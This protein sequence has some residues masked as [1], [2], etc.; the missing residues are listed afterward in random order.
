MH[1]T[2]IAST[3]SFDVDKSAIHGPP[4]F[5]TCNTTSLS[6]DHHQHYGNHTKVRNR[7]IT[8]NIK[9]ISFHFEYSPHY[10]LHG[11]WHDGQVVVSACY[12]WVYEPSDFLFSLRTITE[13]NTIP[14][15]VSLSDVQGDG[16]GRKGVAARG[17]TCFP[18]FEACHRWVSNN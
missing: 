9:P 13:C 14:G 17:C 4:V 12:S 5:A 2:R 18:T 10:R 8:E 15:V 1:Y 16:G 11:H 6:H 3:W 7:F